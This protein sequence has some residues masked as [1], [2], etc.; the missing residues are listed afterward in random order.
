[1]PWFI[2]PNEGI[3]VFDS[4]PNEIYGLCMSLLKEKKYQVMD[5]L[6]KPVDLIF[7]LLGEPKTL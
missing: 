3:I 2:E 5:K 6:L 4:E 7:R 1:M